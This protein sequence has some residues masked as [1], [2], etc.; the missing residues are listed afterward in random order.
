MSKEIQTHQKYIAYEKIRKYSPVF[1]FYCEKNK[2][3]YVY[4][5]QNLIK[6]D[7]GN[8]L[9]IGICINNVKKN[10]SA[11][12][13]QNGIIKVRY[14]GESIPNDTARNIYLAN[15]YNDLK[16]NGFSTQLNENVTPYSYGGTFLIKL[17]T[18]IPKKSKLDND[19][20]KRLI[21]ILLDINNVNYDLYNIYLTSLLSKDNIDGRPFSFYNIGVDL[22]IGVKNKFVQEKFQKLITAYSTNQNVDIICFSLDQYCK[23]LY[24]NIPNPSFT[25]YSKRLIAINSSGQSIFDSDYSTLG[26]YDYNKKSAYKIKLISNPFNKSDFLVFSTLINSPLIAYVDPDDP[27][28][29]NFI[30]SSFT[31]P[32]GTLYEFVQANING[33]GVSARYTV[34]NELYNYNVALFIGITNSFNVNNGESLVVRLSWKKI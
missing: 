6:L 14:F 12:I 19:I 1:S 9:C 7:N 22:D 34:S 25:G 5:S 30:G 4:V 21:T 10:E 24:K 20:K 16:L 17:G 15:S 31:Y 29:N 3:N 2:I 13:V 33:V 23:E 11:K 28:N 8:P 26:I 27:I 32:A 18:S